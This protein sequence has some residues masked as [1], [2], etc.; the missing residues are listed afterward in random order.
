[1]T[2]RDMTS[3]KKYSLGSDS[4]ADINQKKLNT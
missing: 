4:Y 1:M 2:E 3:M